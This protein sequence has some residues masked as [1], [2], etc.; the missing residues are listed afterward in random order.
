MTDP[1]TPPRRTGRPRLNASSAVGDPTEQV[2][3]A[4]G[5]LFAEHGIGGTTM[6]MIATHVGLRQSSLY[7]YFRSRDEV[8][9]ALVERANLVPLA[10]AEVLTSTAASPAARLACF[11]QGDVTSLCEMNVDIGDI[12]R[13]AARE[14]ERFVSYWKER[15]R[16]ERALRRVV[17]EGCDAGQFREVDAGLTAL[18]VM[19]NDEGIQNWYRFDQR[20]P[21]RPSTVARAMASLVVGG[22]LADATELDA[23]LAES[24]SLA[25]GLSKLHRK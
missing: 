2:L 25:A 4:A 18:L 10:L 15:D 11:I 23:V 17:T 8:V 3:D 12:H 16:L 5:A 24:D 20:R 13:V 7:Y 19:G 6:A 14:R 22:L 9:A 21:R 1:V